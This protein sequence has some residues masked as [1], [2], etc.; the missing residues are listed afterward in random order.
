VKADL[1]ES[2]F[3]EAT[4]VTM[5]LLQQLNLELRPKILD[6]DPGTRIASNSFHMGDWKADDIGK[7]SDGCGSYCTAYLWIVPAKAAGTWRFSGGELRLRQKFQLISG[8]LVTRGRTLSIGDGRLFGDQIN[9][10]AGNV[11]YA[12]RIKGNEIE[13]VI[14]DDRNPHRRWTAKRVP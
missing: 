5:F 12:G 13:G 10:R 11:R 14:I 4:V 9:F 2:D 7:V 3:S 1:F 6:L 8:D